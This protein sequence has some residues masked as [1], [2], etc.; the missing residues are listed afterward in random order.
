MGR[1][2][3]E[4]EQ[5]IEKEFPFLPVPL[6]DAILYAELEIR[7]A[8][9]EERKSLSFISSCSMGGGGGRKRRSDRTAAAAVKLSDGLPFVKL[10]DGRTIKQPETWLSIIDAVRQRAE[11]IRE[12]RFP[13]NVLHCDDILYE[14]EMKYRLRRGHPDE[15]KGG[16]SPL[17]TIAGRIIS[18]IRFNILIGARDAGLISFDDAE[19]QREVTA[20]AG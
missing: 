7:Q 19:L 16:C 6:V 9:E 12:N 3:K 18:W 1:R 14:W 4:P 11:S 5:E 17:W 2:K 10:P 15:G 13:V 20:A 8:V